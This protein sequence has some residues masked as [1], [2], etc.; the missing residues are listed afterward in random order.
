MICKR[1]YK[2]EMYVWSDFNNCGE[3]GVKCKCSVLYSV[4]KCKKGKCGIVCRCGWVNCDGIKVNGCEKNVIVDF[5]NCGCCCYY[6]LI[7][8]VNGIMNGIVMC[9]NGWCGI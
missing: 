5:N 4:V 1:G 6:C 2:C 8:F 9:F 3:C 7:G